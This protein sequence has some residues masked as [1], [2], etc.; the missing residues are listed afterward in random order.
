[1]AVVY[2]RSHVDHFGDVRGVVDE[3]D[4]RAG[5]VQ[6]IAP[7]GF[8]E[9]AIA[10]NVYAVEILNKLVYAQPDNAAASSTVIAAC[11][12]RFSAP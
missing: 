8:L 12:M 9:H 2:S 3:S 4:V 7:V 6:I 10:E 11:S 1:M 5:K